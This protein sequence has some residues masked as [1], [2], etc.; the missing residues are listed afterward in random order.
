MNEEKAEKR[1]WKKYLDVEPTIL[2]RRKRDENAKIEKT[3]DNNKAKGESKPA[4]K[5]F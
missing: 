5:V 4:Y 1:A 3:K 2:E